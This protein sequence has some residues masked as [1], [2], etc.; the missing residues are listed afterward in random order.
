MPFNGTIETNF[1][2]VLSGLPFDG[3]TDHRFDSKGNYPFSDGT[4][5][6]QANNVWRSGRTLASGAN[7][8][9]DLAGVLTGMI[10][11][12]ATFSAIKAIRIRASSANTTNLL[13]GGAAS[14]AFAGCFGDAT[15]TVKVKPGGE[16]LWIDPSA[17]GEAVVA[18][19]GD[20][21]K[22]ANGSG[23]SAAYT[24]EILGE[25]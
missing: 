21:L 9:I 17:A 18:G 12:T 7:E 11:G 10:G 14:N 24:I 13:V 25:A 1:R 15:D 20:L 6:Q 2:G 8:N 19:T 4:G 5:A 22:I 23:A 3:S 16:F